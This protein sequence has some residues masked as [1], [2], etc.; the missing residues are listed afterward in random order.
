MAL[1]T[2]SKES[3]H[4]AGPS[5]PLVHTGPPAGPSGAE[6]MQVGQLLVDVWIGGEHVTSERQQQPGELA[7]DPPGSDDTGRGA[8]QPTPEQ[9]FEREGAVPHPVVGKGEPAVQPRG[10][11][12][13]CAR[14]RLR[15]SRPVLARP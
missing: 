8:V 4:P 11:G 6:C 7:P 9:P 10:S 13:A 3:T 14:R 12:P 1:F 2:K 5:T 15:A